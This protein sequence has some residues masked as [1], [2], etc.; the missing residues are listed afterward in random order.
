MRDQHK[1]WTAGRVLHS[2]NVECI[3]SIQGAGGCHEVRFMLPVLWVA[4]TVA[5]WRAVWRCTGEDALL[6]ESGEYNDYYGFASSLNY[7]LRDALD[8]VREMELGRADRLVCEVEAEVVAI[9][10]DNRVGFTEKWKGEGWKK[11]LL[12]VP[13]GVRRIVHGPPLYDGYPFPVRETVET[14]PLRNL[15]VIYTSARS[16]NRQKKA[17][18]DVVAKLR[19]EFGDNVNS[20]RGKF[21]CQEDAA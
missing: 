8:W 13:G 20:V 7:A 5:R 19:S 12:T 2:E 16:R 21:R 9:P 4:E 18:E 6:H 14:F 11:P 3:E 1:H 17:V 15:G 10:H